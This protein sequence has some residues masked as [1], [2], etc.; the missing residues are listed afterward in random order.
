[1]VPRQ[2]ARVGGAAA[3]DAVGGGWQPLLARTPLQPD[4]RHRFVLPDAR[5]GD[6]RAPRRLPGRRHGPAAALGHAPPSDGL[7]ALRDPLDRH[8]MSLWVCR[9]TSTASWTGCSPAPTRRWRPAGRASPATRQPVQTLYLPADHPLVGAA[10]RRPGRLSGAG[11]RGG[12]GG[13]VDGRHHRPRPRRGRA[14]AWPRVLAKLADQPVEDLRLDLEDGYGNRSDEE[15]DTDA[16]RVG[17]VLAELSGDGAPLV[18]GMRAKSLEA[19]TRR[20]GVRSLDLVLGALG[21]T[22]PPGFVVTLPKVT[23]VEQVTRWSCSASA[24]SGARPARAVAALRGAGRDPAVGARC[25][26]DRDRRARSCTP[27]TAGAPACTT[28]PTTTAPPSAS[29]RATRPWTTR[30]PTTRR[31]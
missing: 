17:E 26:R 6:R 4:T 23:S 16:V 25:R 24:S 7:A 18:R 5:P 3:R 29:P 31:P 14:A 21:G 30:S 11:V 1:M 22:L 15:E 8:L 12:R 13:G 20:R 19:P 28:G 2:R 27:P 9:T 10:R